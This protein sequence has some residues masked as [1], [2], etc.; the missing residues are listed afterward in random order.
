MIEVKAKG[1]KPLAIATAADGV[2]ELRGEGAGLR[3][4][5]GRG[6]RARARR[7]RGRRARSAHR[8][9]RRL[10]RRTRRRRARVER[11]AGL[12]HAAIGVER[13][14][15]TSARIGDEEWLRRRRIR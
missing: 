8:P 12:L 7:M 5:V 13:A 6:V 3:A 4:R 1:V 15:A 14:H 11:R 9:R 10:L 2:A